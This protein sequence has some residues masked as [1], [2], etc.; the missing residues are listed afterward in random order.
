MTALDGFT[1]L[2][3]AFWLSPPQLIFPHWVWTII[4]VVGA[5]GLLHV[6]VAPASRIRRAIAV[7]VVSLGFGGLAAVQI[8]MGLETGF[9]PVRLLLLTLWVVFAIHIVVR[10]SYWPAFGAS[11]LDD[12]INWKEPDGQLI[13]PDWTAHDTAHPYDEV[14]E[15]D[16]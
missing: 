2:A 4:F 15:D 6:A 14:D 12:L 9:T 3:L 5:L 11:T 8:G 16:T 13:D 7:G 1:M 10:M